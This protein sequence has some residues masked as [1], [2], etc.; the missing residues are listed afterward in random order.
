MIKAVLVGDEPS[1]TNIH[2][3][4]AFVGAKCFNTVVEWIDSMG[5]D[6]YVCLNS[7]TPENLDKIQALTKEGFKVVA[8]GKKASKRLEKLSIEHYV[9]PHPSPRN[10]ILNNKQQ[11]ALYLLS[12]QSYL[13]DLYA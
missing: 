10:R 9:M 5:L 11:V 1:N 13:W 8:F 6:Y 3:D 2:K 7:H 12:C 4:L